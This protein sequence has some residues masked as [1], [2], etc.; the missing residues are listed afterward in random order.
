MNRPEYKDMVFSPEIMKKVNGRW[1]TDLGNTKSIQGEWCGFV[2]QD[3]VELWKI[4]VYD[5][6][7][8]YTVMP[9]QTIWHGNESIQEEY[10]YYV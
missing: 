2:M 3:G 1:L 6:I 4:R 5:D 8:T 9:K 10:N 7:G